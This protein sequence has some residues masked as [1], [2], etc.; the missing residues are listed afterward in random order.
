MTYMRG[1]SSKRAFKWAIQNDFWL[2]HKKAEIFRFVWNSSTMTKKFFENGILISRTRRFEWYRSWNA[3]QTKFGFSEGVKEF[4]TDWKNFQP[5]YRINIKV[6]SFDVEFF[7]ESI[8]VTLVD[9][10]WKLNFSRDVK[11]LK[12]QSIIKKKRRQ[13]I[14]FKL[15]IW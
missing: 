12:F 15:L 14:F 7:S 6:V 4:Q 2:K 8:H 5:N 1:I 3:L 10:K 9:V 11:K 13:Q